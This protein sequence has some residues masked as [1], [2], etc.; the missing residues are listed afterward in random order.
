MELHFFYQRKTTQEIKPSV[1]EKNEEQD[2]MACIPKLHRRK[3][4]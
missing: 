4:N 3:P 1:T 2:A